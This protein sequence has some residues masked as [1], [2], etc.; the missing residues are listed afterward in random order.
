MHRNKKYTLQEVKDYIENISGYKLLSTN[1]V[2]CDTPLD[3]LH[4][5]CGTIF[6]P[7]F[8]NFR[9]YET[10]CPHCYGSPKIDYNY[11]KNYVESSGE[12]E[13]ISKEYKGAFE[14]LEVLCKKCGNIFKTTW[15]RFH[16]GYRCKICANNKRKNN[17][18]YIKENIE[19]DEDYTL[20]CKEY[21]NA[22]QKLKIQC[23]KCGRIFEMSWNKFS[24]GRRCSCN[25]PGGNKFIYNYLISHNFVENKDFMAEYKI[26][27]CKSK[28]EL[29]FDFR[30]NTNSGYFLVEIQGKQHYSNTNSKYC[31]KELLEHDILKKDYCD[32]H[33]ITLYLIPFL[34]GNSSKLLDNF[35]KILTKEGI[36]K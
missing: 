12:Y 9:K 6:H 31:T 11:V 20:L 19:K 16:Q 1:Y 7:T 8:S 30:I 36:I 18:E 2:N 33:N 27:D 32:N 29:P 10:R 22:R 13:L 4:E 17:Y 34:D 24:Q 14:E 23:N 5:D 25:L 28:R 21:K 26:N 15:A 35:S 3:V